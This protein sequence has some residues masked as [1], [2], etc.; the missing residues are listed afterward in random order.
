[1]W[2]AFFFFLHSF[3]MDIHVDS[4]NV[5]TTY[6]RTAANV[7][8]HHKR[9]LQNKTSTQVLICQRGQSLPDNLIVFFCFFSTS[10]VSD[11]PGMRAVEQTIILL[12]TLVF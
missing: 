9:R 6:G 12:I 3:M 1:M 5:N 4:Q 7:I 11:V 8:P 2:V 10:A